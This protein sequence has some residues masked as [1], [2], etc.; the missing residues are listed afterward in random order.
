MADFDEYESLPE[1]TPLSITMM[2]GAA[3]GVSEHCAMY[4][5]D[6]VKTRMQSL[7]CDKGFNRGIFS[8]L[9]IMVKEEGILRPMR[10]FNAMA[11]GAGPAHALYFS[12]Y[13]H[14]KNSLNHSSFSAFGSNYVLPSVWVQGIA[15]VA[16]TIC[17]DSLMSPADVVKQRMQMCC[18][19]FN[20]TISA[21][22]NIYLNEGVRAFYRSYFTSLSMNIPYQVSHFWMYE[23]STGFLNP[24]GLYNPLVHFV[25]GASAGAVA[26]T[27]T[28]PLDVCKTLLNTQEPSV[29]KRIHSSKIVGLRNAAS[30][31]YGIKGFAGFFQGLQARIVYQMPSTAISWSVYE[32]F[33]QY[34]GSS[35]SSSSGSDSFESSAEYSDR[36]ASNEVIVAKFQ[37]KTDKWES[38]VVP[39]IMAS[40]DMVLAENKFKPK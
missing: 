29:L 8:T 24:S 1:T 25:A 17:H 38:L 7:D 37:S 34:L 31:V 28:M 27:V 39:S 4:P 35:E 19:K 18:S 13:E 16:A 23:L 26:S 10:G 11:F 33:K 14:I 15:G 22:R 9:K 6:S 5:I 21:V 12:T 2:A 30:L 20:T 40:S 3:A 36:N 32:F